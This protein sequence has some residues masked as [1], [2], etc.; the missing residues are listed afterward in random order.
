MQWLYI[1]TLASIFALKPLE[2][3]C[4]LED[5]YDVLDVT[6]NFGKYVFGNNEEKHLDVEISSMELPILRDKEEKVMSQIKIVSQDIDNMVKKHSTLTVALMET[7]MNSLISSSQAIMLLHRIE[8]IQHKVNSM[9][10]HMKL[11]ESDMDKLETST[12]IYM[13]KWFVNPNSESVGH[14]LNILHMELRGRN[15]GNSYTKESNGLHTI[16]RF[17]DVSRIREVVYM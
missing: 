4:I 5:L 7:T 1:W 15:D 9:Y 16:V 6:Y 10:R 11:L 3:Q 2:T 8:R 12:L 13:A 14:L 17:Y